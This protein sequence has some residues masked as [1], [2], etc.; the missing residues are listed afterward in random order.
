MKIEKLQRMKRMDAKLGVG[1]FFNYSSCN[2]YSCSSDIYV[3]LNEILNVG[4]FNASL[5]L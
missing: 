2:I 3:G 5:E 1:F 4:Y